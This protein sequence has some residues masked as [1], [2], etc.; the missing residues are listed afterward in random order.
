MTPLFD[1]HSQ[2]VAWMSQGGRHIFGTDM[3]WLA[4]V[5]GGHAWSAETGNWLGSVPGFTCR[6][7]NGHPVAWN[8]SNSV[9]GTPRPPRPQRL[10]G[11]PSHRG[12]L[13]HLGRLG[14]RARRSP[15]EV[16]HCFTS[17]L[18]Y[19][20]STCPTHPLD[21]M[22]LERIRE[23]PAKLSRNG[24]VK[25][26]FHGDSRQVS[27]WFVRALRLPGSVRLSRACFGDLALPANWRKFLPA[28]AFTAQN[29]GPTLPAT[30]NV[31][32]GATHASP[33]RMTRDAAV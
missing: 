24:P 21:G 26:Q 22:H 3:Q 17:T 2:L 5:S 33:L 1:Q 10:H 14:L 32:V 11:H 29:P 20:N 15:L 23:E 18:G 31:G 25:Q 30:S 7:T 4:Y 13:D 19:P 6:D 28:H 27:P 16:G 9:L 12:R 8:P